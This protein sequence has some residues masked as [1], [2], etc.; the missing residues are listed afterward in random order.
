MMRSLE[1]CD[2][3]GDELWRSKRAQHRRSKRHR[4]AVAR[5]KRERATPERLD[6]GRLVAVVPAGQA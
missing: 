2:E 5:R 6:L 4:D 1:L 3:C